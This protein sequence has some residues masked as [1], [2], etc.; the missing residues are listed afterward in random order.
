[1]ATPASSV[2]TE[3]RRRSRSSTVARAI[4]FLVSASCTVT[5]TVTPAVSRKVTGSVF[6]VTFTEV[7]P[8]WSSSLRASRR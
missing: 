3:V 8:A 1:L 5:C 4:G 2:L 6:A 7:G